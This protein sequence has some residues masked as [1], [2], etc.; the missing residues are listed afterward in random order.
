[1]VNLEWYRTF[2]SVYKNGNF[3]LAAKELFISQPAVSQQIAMLEAHVGYKLFNRKSK[4]VDPTEYAKLLNNLIIEALDRL[5]NVENG[6]RAKAFNANR[7]ITVGISKHFFNSLGNSLI[8]K[9]DYIDFSFHE[10]QDLFELVDTKKVDFAI[11]TQQYDTFDTVLSKVG[12][13]KQVIVGS[14]AI[15]ASEV[16]AKIKKED[17]VA[18]EYWLNEQKWYSHDARI[19]HVK[20]FW[21]HVFDKKRPTI[22]PNYIIPSEFE[23][24]SAMEKNNGIAVSWDCNVKSFIADK[25]LQLVWN[26][27]K[28]PCTDVFLLSGKNDQFNTAFQVIEAELKHSLA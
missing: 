28:M 19:P 11:T 9:F 7:L 3:S 24:L 17:F 8:G 13:I 1:M 18:V 26:S 21:L 22:I 16:K 14:A 27:N 6:F 10:D 20:V 12:Q 15:D 23:M 25:K 5:E 2:K 4:G